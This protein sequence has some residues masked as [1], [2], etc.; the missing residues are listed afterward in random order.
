MND[1][2]L[3]LSLM[4]LTGGLGLVVGAIGTALAVRSR[5]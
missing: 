4:S 2:V 3:I 1:T 5:S